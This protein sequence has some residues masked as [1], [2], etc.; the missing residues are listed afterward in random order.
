MRKNVIVKG[1]LRSRVYGAHR[2]NAYVV[3]NVSA[4]ESKP[5]CVREEGGDRVA[6]G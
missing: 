3:E 1:L 2:K 4:S 6:V 5:R